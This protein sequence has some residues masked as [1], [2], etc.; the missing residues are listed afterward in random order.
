M[1]NIETL[2]LLELMHLIFLVNK[3][4]ESFIFPFLKLVEVFMQLLF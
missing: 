2:A 4:Q 3:N 1:K